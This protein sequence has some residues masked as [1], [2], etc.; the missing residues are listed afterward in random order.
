M[1]TTVKV[2][3]VCANFVFAGVVLAVVLGA[4]FQISGFEQVQIYLLMTLISLGLEILILSLVMNARSKRESDIGIIKSN[5]DAILMNIR[6]DFGTLLEESISQDDLFVKYSLEKLEGLSRNLREASEKKE[7][8]VEEH[9]FESVDAVLAPFMKERKRILRYVWIP[10]L[11]EPFFE[12]LPWRLYFKHACTLA[13]DKQLS[14]I[15]TVLVLEDMAD[16]AN[17]RMKLLLGF[18][19]TQ[20]RLECMLVTRKEYDTRIADAHFHH[21]FLDFGIYGSSLLY[22]SE[23]FVPCVGVFVKDDKAIQKYIGVFDAMWDSSTTIANPATTDEE[24][25]V[26]ELIARDEHMCR[27]QNARD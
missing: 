22:L 24:I 27:D 20:K 9:H 21:K 7:L 25:G 12:Y 19:K 5:C 8:R 18:Y 23:S 26:D 4:G 17:D 13:K 3:L 16:L 2:L 10:D 14:E 11:K 15:R 6:M 1:T